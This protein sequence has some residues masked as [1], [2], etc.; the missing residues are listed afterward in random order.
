[1]DKPDYLNEQQLNQLKLL[2]S[3][4]EYQIKNNQLILPLISLPTHS[5]AL[6]QIINH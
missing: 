5:I 2:N 3:P 4:K 6:L 1:M